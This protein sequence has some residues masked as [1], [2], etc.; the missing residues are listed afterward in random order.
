[1]KN[2]PGPVKVVME[3]VCLMLGVKPKKVRAAAMHPPSTGRGAHRMPLCSC[4]RLLPP[5]PGRRKYVQVA[6]ANQQCHPAAAPLP[7]PCRHCDL[8]F[9][10]RSPTPPTL[11]RSWTT[12][13]P[14]PRACWARATSWRSYRQG[15][16]AWL[17]AHP[18]AHATSGIA[19][20]AP[21]QE[22]DKDNIAP[23]I[24]QAIRP[25]LERPEFAP[26]TVKKASKAAYGLCSWVRAME[27]Y[28]RW[29]AGLA[30]APFRV[31]GPLAHPA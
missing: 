21:L 18:P 24:I 22:Y 14:P 31:A 19:S 12:T 5:P 30:G 2:P 9:P 20:P 27:A 28:D 3:T 29:V 25:Y 13:G 11:P 6:K 4:C 8:T 10:R 23:A 1:M 7:P 26:D 17:P 15:R 16:Q